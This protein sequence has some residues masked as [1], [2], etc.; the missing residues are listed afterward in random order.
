MDKTSQQKD[1]KKDY[2]NNKKTHSNFDE[3]CIFS[4]IVRNLL[5]LNKTYV[6]EQIGGCFCPISGLNLG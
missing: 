2:R 1:V 4:H 6:S 5:E 3:F